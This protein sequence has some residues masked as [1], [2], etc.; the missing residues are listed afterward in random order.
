MKYDDKTVTH[1]VIPAQP[2]WYVSILDGGDS[3]DLRDEPI[4]AWHV[5]MEMDN[6]RDRR[7]DWRLVTPITSDADVDHMGN[8]WAIKNPDGKYVV[9]NACSFD[10]TE[11]AIKYLVERK[12]KEKELSAKIM[13]KQK[14]KA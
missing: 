7:H 3:D 1:A 13:A 2:G 11:D 5:E 10:N 9:P 6:D 8:E 12:R 4:I 14:E